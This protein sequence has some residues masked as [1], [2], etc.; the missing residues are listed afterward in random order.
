MKNINEVLHKLAETKLS[1][2]TFII[3]ELERLYYESDENGMANALLE[4]DL[5]STK[6]E[7]AEK[8]WTIKQLESVRDQLKT[9]L[10]ECGTERDALRELLAE[11][12][13]KIT[14]LTN[15]LGE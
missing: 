2:P 11:R 10:G 8:D 6:K 5:L 3:D 7:L 4:A 1:C 9:W 14:W 12:D 15:E 13:Q